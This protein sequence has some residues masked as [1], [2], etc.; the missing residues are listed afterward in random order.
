MHHQCGPRKSNKSTQPTVKELT[1]DWDR[2]RRSEKG[3]WSSTSSITPST[4][5]SPRGRISSLCPK[6]TSSSLSSTTLFSHRT[7]TSQSAPPADF[8]HFKLLQSFDIKYAPVKV[9][10]WR[11]ERTGLT[12]V[13]GEHASPVVRWQLLFAYNILIADQRI[14]YYCF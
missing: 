9:S 14:L 11:S 3:N 6:T 10:K 12:V 4:S 8:G 13:V 5:P 1:G 7:M 2:E